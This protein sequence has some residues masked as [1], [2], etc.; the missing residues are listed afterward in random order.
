MRA[1]LDTGAGANMMRREL[2][3][4]T[5][6]PIRPISGTIPRILFSASGQPIHPLGMIELRWYFNERLSS[7]KSYDIP[8]LVCP[9]TAP[10]DVVLGFEFLQEAR[11][12]KF[13]E[14]FSMV[15]V[16]EDGKWAIL[17]V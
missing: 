15:L 5:G 1:L 16:P 4:L 3:V 13:N 2:A 11:I 12:F 9:D 7:A 6:F 14:S 17:D 10:Y 8:F